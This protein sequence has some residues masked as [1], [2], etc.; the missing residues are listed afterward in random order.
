[1][2]VGR[3]D[4]KTWVP[5]LRAS[6]P[7]GLIALALGLSYKFDSFLLSLTRGDAE[8][9]YY[10]AAYN[11]VFSAVVFSNVLNT[12]LY[13]SLTRQAARDASRLTALY[14]R[15]LRYLMIVALPIAVG[16]TVLADQ[17]V[18]L[19]FRAV[20][21]PAVPAL[22]IVIWVVP[23]MYLSEFLGYVLLIAGQEQRAARAVMLSTG[24][25]VALNFI[26][27]PQF[28]FLAAAVMTVV[29]E[30]VLVGQYLW[31]LSPHLQHMAWTRLARPLLAA[32][33]MGALVWGLR[34]LPVWLNAPIAGGVYAGLLLL[35]RAIGG[36]EWRFVLSLRDRER[37]TI[38]K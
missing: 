32:L 9:G 26:L 28:G 12:A 13:P 1:V 34:D 6:F 36:D 25:N 4:V 21:L 5:L 11:L 16:T 37:R 31:V 20:Y 23:L 7:F 3:V 22:Q 17:L 24:V 8:T 10:N 29:T 14:E 38:L 18:P 30:A 19:L 27:V 2:R 15:A 33:L 35:F